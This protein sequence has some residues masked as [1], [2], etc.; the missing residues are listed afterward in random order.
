MNAVVRSAVRIGILQGHQML[1]VH[2]GFDGL[3]QGMVNCYLW[4]PSSHEQ[5]SS[6]TGWLC[7][8]ADRA[9][10]LVRSG[11][12]DRK[13]RLLSGHKEVRFFHK[14]LLILLICERSLYDGFIPPKWCSTLPHQSSSRALI[15][16]DSV[17]SLLWR[18]LPQEFMEEISLNIA[19][20]NIHAMIIIGGFEVR[21][22]SIE[23]FNPV[24]FFLNKTPTFSGEGLPRR[25][26]DGAG[27]RE[28][29]GTLHPPCRCSR[30]CLQQYSWIWLQCGCWYRTQ[31][32]NDGKLTTEHNVQDTETKSYKFL[33][34]LCFVFFFFCL[35]RHVTGSNSLLLVPRGEFSLLRQWED[36]AAT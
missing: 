1:A 24:I 13:G 29:W 4:M 22:W 15:S 32:Y 35:F 9:D 23:M 27:Q 17:G 20:F 11:R 28:V 33:S 19:K 25:S 16:C 34:S 30:H 6:T 12:M 3:V 7:S 26:A 2:D 10:R 14:L 36:T 8:C 31:H 21:V 5:K 18:S